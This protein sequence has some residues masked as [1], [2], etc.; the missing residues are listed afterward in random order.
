MIILNQTSVMANKN[1]SYKTIR[2]VEGIQF[3]LYEKEP[4][5]WVPHSSTGPAII[6]PKG[7]NKPDQYYLFGLPYSYDKWLELSKPA[8]KVKSQEDFVE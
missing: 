7:I 4:G 2:T 8:R 1:S 6:Y 5:K 3:Q